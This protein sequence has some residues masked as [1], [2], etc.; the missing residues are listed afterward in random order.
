MTEVR[1]I[2]HCLVQNEGRF[3]WYAINSVL[4]YVD[5]IMIWDMSSIDGSREII[6]SIKS[7]KIEFKEVPPGTLEGLTKQRQ[8]MLDETS[9]DYTWIMILDGDEIWPDKPIKVVTDF[10]RSH[11]EYESIVVRTNNLVGDIFHRLPESAGKYSLAGQVGHLAL[12][13]MNSKMIPGLNVQKPHGQQGF[14]DGDN[15][16]VQNRDQSKIKFIDVYYHHAT[17]LQRSIQRSSDLVV[18]KRDQKLKHE[19][20]EKIPAH[21]IP[22][23]FF[24]EDRP[25]TVPDVTLRAPIY[26]WLISF[27]LTFP[28]RLKRIFFPGKHGY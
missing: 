7:S 1:I 10:A 15:C 24:R 20:G 2:V 8:R 21:Q 26:F 17:H 5:K 3:I 12:R 14:Y 6:E 13:F 19:L 25:G 18:P 28:R 16:L 23:V 27:I 11:P 9:S 22:E 4:P